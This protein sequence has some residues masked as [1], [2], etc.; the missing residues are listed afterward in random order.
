MLN[1]RRSLIWLAVLTLL[2]SALITRAQ[3]RAEGFI[4]T[5]FTA[6]CLGNTSPR[7][8]AVQFDGKIIVGGTFQQGVGV[9]CVNAIDRMGIN[10]SRDDTFTSPLLPGDQVHAVALQGNKIIVAGRMGGSSSF[11][12]ARL[13]A[14]GTVDSGFQRIIQPFRVYYALLVQSDGKIIAAGDANVGVAGTQPNGVIVRVNA[15]G[16]V[17]DTFNNNGLAQIAGNT[18]VIAALAPAADGKILVGGALNDLRG[19]AREGL[20]RLDSFGNIDGSY[21]PPFQNAIVHALLTQPDG[22]TLVAGETIQLTG[23]IGINRVLVRLNSNGTLDETFQ[24]LNGNGVGLS[25]LRQGDGKIILGHSGGVM[26]LETNGSVDTAFG[27]QLGIEAIDATSLAFTANSNILVGASLVRNGST[28]RQGVTRLFG[29]VAPIPPKPVIVAQPLS[30]IVGSGTNVTFSVI[31]TGAPPLGFQWFKNKTKINGQTGTNLTLVGVDSRSAGD[32][33]VIVTNLGGATTSLVAHLTVKFNTSPLTIITNGLGVVLPDLT[34]T[35]LEIGRT[36]TITA[37]PAVGNLFS[38][39]TGGATSSSPVLT[40]MMQTNLE[41]VVNFVPSPFIPVKGTYNGL[42]YNTDSPAHTNAGAVTVVLDDKGGIRG[43]V[44]MGTKVRKFKSAFSLERT[45]LVTLPATI[46]DPALTLAM[47]IDVV[48]AIIT[49]SVSFATNVSTN[50]STLL[51]YRN[52]FSSSANPAPTVGLYNAALPGVEDAAS[53]PGGDG[54]S[55]LT[56]ST[57]GRVSGKGTLADGSPLKILSATS[58]DAQVPVYVAL[59]GGRG[60]IFG[61]LTVTNGDASDVRGTL[62]WTKPSSVGGTF[63][64]GGFVHTINPIGSFYTA[65]PANTPVF[66]LVDGLAILSGGNLVAP[67]TSTVTLGGDNKIIS[68]NQL[69]LT[70]SPAKGTVSGSFIDPTSNKK[71]T[72]KGIALPA[73]NQARGFFLGTDQSGRVFVGEPL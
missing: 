1:A 45:A 47:D 20:G 42:F 26:R 51:A 72:V 34:K 71:R 30:Q 66:T 19:A 7:A 29:F 67:L 9:A 4:D 32:Y 23:S 41:L 24:P 18:P 68:D 73:Q 3:Q 25:L 56:V 40:F 8:F 33:T 57:S 15:N 6:Q 10:G 61:W 13:N 63:Y 21:N 28:Q 64:P 37:R 46:K 69:T 31:A 53:A 35:E 52:P 12:L 14:N 58:G 44:R 70:I 60:S 50:A 59:Y 48:N 54:F 22:K 65:P 17:D 5:S 16:V 62:W 43:S 55:A 11:P 27:P 39:W 49:G 2:S 36:Y 38:N